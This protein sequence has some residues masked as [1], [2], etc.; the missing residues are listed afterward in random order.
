MCYNTRDMFSPP[1]FIRMPAFG[2]DISSDDIRYVELLPYGKEMRLGRYGSVPLADGI[3]VK[4]K[5]EDPGALARVLQELAKKVRIGYANIS[6]PEEQSFLTQIDIPRASRKDL[7]SAVEL[8]LEE[9][10]PIPPQDASFDYV[11][12]DSDNEASHVIAGVLPGVV[13][14]QYV[15]ICKVA[16]I[17]PKVMEF[18]SHAMAR[19]MFEKNARGAYMGIDIGRDITHIFIVLDREVHFSALLDIGGHNITQ[20]LEEKLQIS[21]DEANALKIKFGLV[22]NSEHP[23]VRETILPVLSQLRESIMRY[24]T[25]WQHRH[26]GA[27]A[28]EKVLLTGGGANLIGI[29]EYLGQGVNASFAVAN[30]WVNVCDFESYIPPITHKESQGY[31]AAIGLALRGDYL[32]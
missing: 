20:A 29:V 16:G 18:Q 15:D 7:R 1:D 8:R 27:F 32:E 24:F 28:I 10:V 22:G 26:D 25:Y 31:A 19:A 2:I 30:P 17:V 12:I 21:N 23:E 9:Y 11:L 3:V 6:L 14:E 13:V 4:G 5:V